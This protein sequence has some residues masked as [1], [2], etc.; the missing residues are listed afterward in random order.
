MTMNKV[1][2]R[3]VSLF[4]L[5]SLFFLIP[6]PVSATNIYVTPTLQTKCP[7]NPC[8][9]LSQYANESTKYLVSNT[10]MIFLLG[11][12][13]LNAQVHVTNVSNFSMMGEKEKE[14]SVICS[15]SECG[16]FFFK[17]VTELTIH[18][19]RFSSV[20]SSISGENVHNFLLTNCTFAHNEDTAVLFG[21]SD[22]TLDG[23]VFVNNSVYDPEGTENLFLPGGGV[24]ILSGNATLRG[25][26][27]FLNNSCVRGTCAGSAI[28]S[29]NST[30]YLGGNI[31]FVNN[32]VENRLPAKFEN[33]CGGG[34]L[35]TISTNV[36]VTGSVIFANNSVSNSY[37]KDFSC[38]IGGGG[39]L[40]FQSNAILSGQM[41][42][43]SNQAK[44]S[45]VTGCG[46][47]LYAFG[48]SM[49]IS[50]SLEF[51]DN[52]ADFEGGGM[53]A[54]GGGLYIEGTVSF[55]HNFGGGLGGGIHV[56]EVQPM[57]VNGFMF[58][59]DNH[60]N[61]YDCSVKTGGSAG[62]GWRVKQSTVNITGEVLVTNN[63]ALCEGGGISIIISN[64]STSGNVSVINNSAE[65]AGGIEIIVSSVD[66]TNI[67]FIGNSAEEAG[68]IAVERGK[69]IFSGEVSF[70]NNSASIQGGGITLIKS[71]LNITSSLNMTKNSASAYGGAIITNSSEVFIYG[72]VFITENEVIASEG[73][74]G[75]MAITNGAVYVFGAVMIF[76]NS[77]GHAGGGM[78]LYNS[79][80][81]IATKM[82]LINNTAQLGGAMFVRDDTTLIYCSPRIHGAECVTAECTFRNLSQGHDQILMEFDGNK[83]TAA[84]SVL[85]GG[86]IDR[87]TV[88]GQ[89][90]PNSGK[91]FDT[92]IDV[93]KQPRIPSLITSQ[94]FRVCVCENGHPNCARGGSL[95]INTYPGKR[96]SIPAV[97]IGQR[98]GTVS[99]QWVNAQV[100]PIT[101]ARLDVFEDRQILLEVCSNLTYTVYSNIAPNYLVLYVPGSCSALDGSEERL[102][103]NV[104][105]NLHC[106]PA[107]NLSGPPHHCICEQRLQKY[108]NS[109]DINGQTILHDGD[110]WVGYDNESNSQGLILHPHC[111][112]DYCK[113]EPINFTLNELDLQCKGNRTGLLCGAC[114]PGLSLGLGSSK[115]L[116]CSNIRLLLILA[117]AVMGV[118]FVLFFLV[119]T[120][121]TVKSGAISG[122]IFYASIV[123]ANQNI[124]FPPGQK[125]YLG[126]YIMPW[127]SLDFGIE[128]CF[129]D[130]MDTY[131]KTWLQFV[132]PVYVLVL[133][134][135]IA[136]LNKWKKIFYSNNDK[137]SD[138]IPHPW[139]VMA[140][141]F[142]LAYGKIVRTIIVSLSYTTLEYPNEQTEIVWLYD[143]NIKY[144]HGKHLPLFVVSVLLSAA[145]IIPFTT[146]L[147]FG[148]L[149]Q[150]IPMATWMKQPINDILKLYHNPY[151]DAHGYW[152]GLLLA[153]RLALFLIFGVNALR[154]YSENLLAISA[155]SLG[156]L[157]WPWITGGRVYKNRW[158]GVLEAS[159][160]LNLGV[161]A[162]A[163]FYVQKSGGNQSIVAYIS[164]GTALLSF[165]VT[166][167][168]HV[169]RQ[170]VQIKQGLNCVREFCCRCK[171]QLRIRKT[172]YEEIHGNTDGSVNYEPEIVKSTDSA[173]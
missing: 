11:K 24:A 105:I 48:T 32:T 2:I 114:A 126:K 151:V 106:P 57:I 41:T 65:I 19:L 52:A 145:L 23:N 116:S 91:V 53:H 16:G 36:L 63:S 93:S 69:L 96:F 15:G 136:L 101:V 4:P 117:F 111:P 150:R 13:T 1:P 71:T 56:A 144:L 94:P 86:S 127:I 139:Y 20:S 43:L 75:G 26:N 97:T 113:A 90:L 98:N 47:G 70:I 67:V 85:V 50:G 171:C 80:L 84:G 122:L 147:L 100:S 143:A 156:L 120:I 137:S 42:F 58:L 115:C 28:Y 102:S 133:L 170:R 131:A 167:V 27:T 89:L 165:L 31:S 25:Q 81:T 37:N 77:A 109:C 123:G 6:L 79:F 22:I 92:I 166:L 12:H 88:N 159:Y 146:F 8:Q 107:F 78:W 35:F 82:K 14:T 99:G 119:F 169:Y 76:N 124:F 103:I 135:I 46:G 95:N 153:V 148:Q 54:E 142:I 163:T 44:G 164:T 140:T 66:I 29:L 161:F 51:I 121:F 61:T 30:L 10:T 62:G 21:Y 134:L 5:L 87:C 55:N 74:G 17:N 138:E 104:N 40:L 68:G 7:G 60:V 73:N 9:M 39:A 155:A 108:T 33:A 125:N 3:I 149:I 158:F 152:P 154:D 38:Q 112:F 130:G 160:M 118:V 45:S 64:V 157:A 49:A 132:F 128:T 172:V 18:S 110:Y 168:Y 72:D 141:F 83:A 34:T 173:V 129:Y 162:A 59:N